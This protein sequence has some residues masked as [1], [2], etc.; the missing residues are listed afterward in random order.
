MFLVILSLYWL[1]CVAGMIILRVC[2]MAYE[3]ETK[4]RREHK[5]VIYAIIAAPIA[6]PCLVGLCMYFLFLHKEEVLHRVKVIIDSIT[7]E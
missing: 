2:R 4:E 3:K 1:I 7:E 5:S 6:F